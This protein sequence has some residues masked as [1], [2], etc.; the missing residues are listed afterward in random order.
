MAAYLWAGPYTCI[1]IALGMVLG[2]NFHVV[3]GVIEIHG[4]R[5]AK[6]LSRL[7]VPAAAITI[8][9][10]VLGQS[11]QWLHQTRRHERVHVRQY[12]RWGLF[13]IPAYVIASIALY[14]AGKDGYRA[15]P[16]EVEAFRT[17]DP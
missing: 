15:N 14:A 4:Q 6:W 1:G 9:H 13:F 2:G 12:E 3:D 11:A 10:T 7:W 8:G 16:F 17:D 5:I